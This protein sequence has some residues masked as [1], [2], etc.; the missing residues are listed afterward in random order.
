MSGLRLRRLQSDHEA[1]RRLAHLHPR[2]EVEGV[3][4]N[5]PQRYVLVLTAKSLREKDDRVVVASRHRVEITLPLTYPRDP[6]FSRMLTPVFHP[7]IAPHAICVGDDWSAAESLDH[8]IQRIGEMLCF[9]SYNVQSPLN[10]RAAR[11]VE[12][13][14]RRLPIDKIEFYLDLSAAPVEEASAEETRCANCGVRSAGLETCPAGHELCDGCAAAC[15]TC[16]RALCLV[17]GI[18]ECPV[19][20]DPACG[21]CSSRKGIALVCERGH[22]LCADCAYVCDGCGRMLCMLC[23]EIAGHACVAEDAE[24]GPG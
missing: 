15:P 8:L 3:E 22:A 11:W 14:E 12:E 20:G 21:N 16:G 24:A 2:I 13:N 7:N 4:G 1:V 17:C 23:D 9:Q 18:L 5:P 10:G 19:C 6:P